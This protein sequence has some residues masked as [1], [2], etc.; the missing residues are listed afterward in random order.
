M[1]SASLGMRGAME[2]RTAL[3]VMMRM[4]L[5]AS[6]LSS[7]PAAVSRARLVS[8]SGGKV[9]EGGSRYGIYRWS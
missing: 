2:S 7:L 3:V 1:V 8:V 6:D 4:R 5:P 9:D